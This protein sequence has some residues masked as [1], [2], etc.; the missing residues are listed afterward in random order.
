MSS[1]DSSDEQSMPDLLQSSDD[2][3]ESEHEH[4][5]DDTSRYIDE[6]P[7]VPQASL[8]LISYI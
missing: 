5:P 2:E 8:R 4:G 1:S 7:R 3:S 6:T